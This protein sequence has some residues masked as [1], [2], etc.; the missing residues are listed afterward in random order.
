MKGRTIRVTYEKRGSSKDEVGGHLRKGMICERCLPS[1]ITE[2]GIDS[3]CT[4]PL[5]SEH[6]T[7]FTAS[8]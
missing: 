5:A 8:S 7:H 2:E 3:D 4:M 6:Q 1:C